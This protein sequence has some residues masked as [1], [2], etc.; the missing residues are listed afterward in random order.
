MLTD[1]HCHPFDK[2]KLT[3][4][5]EQGFNVFASISA[6]DKEEFLYN[7][8][9]ARNADASMLSRF[10]PCFAVH[11][12]L[13]A[14][15]IAESGEFTALEL[16]NSLAFLNDLAAAGRL[17]AIGECGF[18]LFNAAYKET[19]NIQ[20]RVFAAHMEV[21]LRYDLPVVLHI[22][23]AVHKIFANIKTLKKCSSV[24]FHSWQG[25]LEDAKSILNHGVNAYFSFGNTILLNHKKAVKCC[26]LLPAERILT[27]T[28]APYQPR[29][30]NKISGWED[31]P[32]I[33]EET[34]ALRGVQA[35]ELERQIEENFKNAFFCK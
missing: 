9:M 31:L 4:G 32:Y 8:E 21:S 29:H 33:I 10:L 17:S 35:D 34:G 1:A 2:E 30:G 3:G 24:V 26:A 25:T 19:E 13:P 20:D 16:E 12:Q 28:D 14:L 22:R 15:R 5:K 27:E 23:R 6:C 7:E 11:P 18:D